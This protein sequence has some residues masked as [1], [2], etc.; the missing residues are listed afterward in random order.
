M[1]HV[2]Q[3][4]YQV[5][6]SGVAVEVRSVHVGLTRCLTTHGLVFAGSVLGLALN[7]AVLCASSLLAAGFLV[8]MSAATLSMSKYVARRFSR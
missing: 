3:Y 6:S 7:T 4:I 2:G 8:N 1:L 5:L